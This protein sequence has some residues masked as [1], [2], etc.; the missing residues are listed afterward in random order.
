MKLPVHV[1]VKEHI[2]VDEFKWLILS[3]LADANTIDLWNFWNTHAVYELLDDG[4][5]LMDEW[6][7]FIRAIIE[8]KQLALEGKQ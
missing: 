7:D 3:G 5:S 4:E 8:D 2:D 1:T 6:E